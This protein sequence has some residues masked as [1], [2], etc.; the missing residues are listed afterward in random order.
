MASVILLSRAE[1][2]PTDS[3]ML[4]SSAVAGAREADSSMATEVVFAVGLQA[5][6]TAKPNAIKLV[7][8]QFLLV[9]DSRVMF[10]NLS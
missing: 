8:S 3:G 5:M 6:I 7:R 4:I 2:M 9:V 1:S 10:I